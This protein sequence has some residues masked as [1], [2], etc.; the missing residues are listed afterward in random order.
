MQARRPALQQLVLA[1][2]FYIRKL[3]TRKSDFAQKGEGKHALA[4]FLFMAVLVSKFFV[5]YLKRRGRA[6]ELRQRIKFPFAL[7]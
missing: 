2:F 7:P 6:Q 4:F 1:R 5:L 3:V